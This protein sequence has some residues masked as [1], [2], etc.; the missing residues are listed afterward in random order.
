MKCFIS[1]NGSLERKIGSVPNK[2][3]KKKRKLDQTL[4]WTKYKDNGSNVQLV[5]D[6]QWNKNDKIIL[7]VFQKHVA[8]IAHKQFYP[9]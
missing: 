1:G 9:N 6:V 5:L 8:S 4:L 7:I 3:N 2:L